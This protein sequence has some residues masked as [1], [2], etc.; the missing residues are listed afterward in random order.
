M[1]IRIAKR[2]AA[3]A[4][5]IAAAAALSAQDAEGSEGLPIESDWGGARPTLYSKGDQTFVISLGTIFP[6][7]FYGESGS[8]DSNLETGGTGSL[9]YNYFINPN[10]ALGGELGGMFAGTLGKNMLYI[11]PFGFR[12]TYQFLAGRFEFPISLTLGGASQSYLTDDYFGLFL[13]PA[14]AAY[15]RFNPDWS[16]GLNAA[17]WWVPQWVEEGG[18][19]VHGNFVELTLAARYHF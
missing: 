7:V 3:A 2:A 13:K 15:W 16:F 8:I 19:D 9:N 10:V 18:K 5:L 6:T 1:S 12:A 14:A 17:W 4:L 11:V